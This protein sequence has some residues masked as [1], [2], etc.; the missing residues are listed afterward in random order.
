[1]WQTLA[2]DCPNVTSTALHN[3]CAIYYPQLAALFLSKPPSG[4]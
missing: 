3:R 4:T 1:V 2:A